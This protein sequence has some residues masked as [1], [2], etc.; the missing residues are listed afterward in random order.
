MISIDPLKTPVTPR[1]KPAVPA[2]CTHQEW[3]LRRIRPEYARFLI[4]GGGFG[5]S[6]PINLQSENRGLSSR[7]SLSPTPELTNLVKPPNPDF[8]FELHQTNF[9][10][11]SEHRRSRYEPALVANSLRPREEEHT[12]CELE[13]EIANSG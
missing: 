9:R 8:Q 1:F 12:M 10:M 3:L 6:W 11:S 13:A 7:E 2:N 4:L 5:F